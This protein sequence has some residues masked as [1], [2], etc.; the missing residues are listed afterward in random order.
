MEYLKYL[1][2]GIEQKEIL[3]PDS[4]FIIC[5][6]WWGRG[7]VNK[8]STRKLTYDA[9]INRLIEQCRKLKINYCF[10]EYSV[11]VEN[12]IPYQ[13]CIGLKGSFIERCIEQ[14]Q[15]TIVYIDTDMQVVQYPTLFDIDADCF[16][17]NWN[18][19]QLNCYNPYQVEL[20]G[21]IMAFGNTFGSKALL[22]VLNEYML[23]HLHLVED[24]SFSGI[25]S[26]H[27]MNAYLRCVWIPANYLYMYTTHEYDP[28]IGQYTRIATLKEDLAENGDYKEKDI[29]FIHEDLETAELL[30]VFKGRITK[31]RWPPNV[32]R[33]LGEKLRCENIVYKNYL[34]FGMS[35]L[36][37]KHLLTDFKMRQKEGVIKNVKLQPLPKLNAKI[38]RAHSNLNNNSE[39]LIISLYDK[40]ISNDVVS[41]FKENCEKFQMDYVIYRVDSIKKINKAVLFHKFLAKYKRNMCY[42]DIN[43]QIRKDPKLFNVKN[44]DFMTINLDNTNVDGYLCSDMRILR[45]LNDNLYF[46]AYN[47]VV[48]AFLKI[49]AEHNT[50]LKY[51]HKNL[52]YA[53]NISV[54]INKLRCYWLPRDYLLGPVLKFEKSLT[55]SFFNNVYSNNK[56]RAI[57]K[58]L[59]QCG[60]K[61]SLKDGDPIKAHYYGSMNGAH[62]HNK[63]GKLFLEF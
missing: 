7:N 17:L 8:N 41:K 49:W 47:P 14:F 10:T 2:Q 29:V 6:Y 62:Y 58:Q 52:E 42:L 39:C 35:S 40:N 31:N 18:E 38:H 4:K 13:I 22:K 50:S 24:K 43:Y 15:K 12:K 44:I 9:Q 16:F 5:S 36:Q 45:M 34:D 21:G 32:Y 55:Y 11:F 51:Q 53:F 20:P 61:P 57:T 30:D 59:Q 3:N 60:L 27:F 37:V 25:I 56:F 28:S 26:R 1:D 33:Q 63:Y 46:F 54:A 23:N 19:Y 48:L